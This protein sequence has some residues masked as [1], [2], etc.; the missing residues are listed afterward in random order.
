ME[1]LYEHPSVKKFVHKVENPS[2]KNTLIPLNSRVCIDGGSGSGK[3]H[4]LLSFVVRS[5]NTFQ[6]IVC[7]NQGIEEPLYDTLR[8]KLGKKGTITFF[9]VDDYP[10]AKELSKGL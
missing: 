9:T 10:T 8:D 4:A 7:I 6:H 5:P 2:V 1:I 3:T